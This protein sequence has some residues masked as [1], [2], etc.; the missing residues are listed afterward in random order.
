MFLFIYIFIYFYII[1]YLLFDYS[2]VCKLTVDEFLL[3]GL[4]LPT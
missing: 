3:F 1:M 2:A 4:K